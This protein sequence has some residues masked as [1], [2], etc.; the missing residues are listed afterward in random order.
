M[1]TQHLCIW[2]LLSGLGA[3]GALQ[4]AECRG[5]GAARGDLQTAEKGAAAQ[6]SCELVPGCLD[7]DWRMCRV[8]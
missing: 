7:G 2:E 6:K 8:T 3:A 1:F 4:G 5:G